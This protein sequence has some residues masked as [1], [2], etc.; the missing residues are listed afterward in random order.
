[1][2]A[3]YWEKG[4]KIDFKN[5]GSTAIEAGTVVTIGSRVGVAGT[6][7]AV[8]AVGSLVLDG[9]FVMPKATGA[10]TLG[11]ALY[12]DKSAGNVTTTKAESGAIY[13]GIAV[14]A[15]GSSDAEVLVRIN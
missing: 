13:A 6:D 7:I 5:S 3:R 8:G 10:V 9:V 11:Q 4:V 1:M 2:K 14:E 12:F 15:A